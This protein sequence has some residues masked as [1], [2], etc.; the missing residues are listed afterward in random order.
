MHVT[1]GPELEG[2]SDPFSAATATPAYD[3]K[4][5]TCIERS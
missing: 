4:V 5:S 1:D 3:V 2:A